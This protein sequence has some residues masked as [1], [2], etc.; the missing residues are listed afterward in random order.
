M[1]RR[2]FHFL[3]TIILCILSCI[4]V[5]F[6]IYVMDVFDLLEDPACDGEPRPFH[7]G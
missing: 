6:Y 1:K 2:I 5:K 4:L 3:E 7:E